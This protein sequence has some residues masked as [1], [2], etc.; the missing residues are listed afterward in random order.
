VR[1]VR[2]T[3]ARDVL[4][5]TQQYIG[6]AAVMAHMLV[7]PRPSGTI[8]S[9]A[10]GAVTVNVVLAT[11]LPAALATR[12]YVPALSI[13][14]SSNVAIPF[15][16]VRVSVPESTAPVVF[17]PNDTA[18]WFVAPGIVLPF[19]SC[20]ATDTGGVSTVF[21]ATLEGCAVK[22]SCATGFGHA[23]SFGV[24]TM[25]CQKRRKSS[26]TLS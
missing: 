18:T 25:I 22:A 26:P 12:M 21:V 16:G 6:P 20:S 5:C 2:P 13:V 4:V 15:D 19:A 24:I 11:C 9:V 17:W 3:V 23:G 10:E 14:K 8:E 1:I 7:L